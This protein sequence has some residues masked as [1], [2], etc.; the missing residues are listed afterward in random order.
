M[1]LLGPVPSV[2]R[3]QEEDEEVIGAE[4][5]GAT[6]IQRP[7]RDARRAGV[8]RWTVRRS[9]GGYR[10]TYD[11]ERQRFSGTVRI[12]FTN[13]FRTGTWSLTR[14]EGRAQAAFTGNRLSATGVDGDSMVVVW[15]RQ[16]ERW[17]TDAQSRRAVEANSTD[18]NIG[19]GITSDIANHFGRRRRANA[20]VEAAAAACTNNLFTE[21]AQ[22]WTRSI[23]CDWATINL[24]E[25]C[26]EVPSACQGD[27]C[28][29][30]IEGC[31]CA[32]AG[33]IP[34]F[35][36]LTGDYACHCSRHGYTYGNFC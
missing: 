24:D 18:F 15:D 25:A 21:R 8:E 16:R 36:G 33:D 26:N 20:A 31:D 27:G 2:V 29:R 23:A 35:G 6:G 19:F 30:V 5:I 1:M 14:D 12:N 10:V 17:E 11:H 22:A 9:S 34:V 4:G 3:A 32:C 13:D 7:G 28:C